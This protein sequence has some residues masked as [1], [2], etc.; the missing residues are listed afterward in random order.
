MKTLWKIGAIVTALI[1]FQACFASLPK[2]NQ[3]TAPAPVM[4]NSGKYMSPYT[5]DDTIAEWVDK[6][7]TAQ[8]LSGIGAAV[9]REVGSRVVSSIPLVGS[10]FGN[11]AGKAAGRAIAVEIS[12]GW[13]KIRASS[14]IS[15]NSYR[16]MAVWLYVTKSQR[17]EYPKVLK[18]TGGIYPDLTK[19]FNKY[20]K[21][22]FKL[23]KKAAK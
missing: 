6:G 7:I 21:K 17:E 13:D 14:D 9:G 18:L 16:E 15:F 4:N 5:Q 11:K 19:K 20:I 8:A 12:G 3:L 2:P 1:I 22:E 10:L 23:Q